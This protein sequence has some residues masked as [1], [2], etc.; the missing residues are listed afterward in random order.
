MTGASTADIYILPRLG[1]QCYKKAI[2]IDIEYSWAY[3][4]LSIAYKR[5]GDIS[6]YVRNLK[7]SVRL[8]KREGIKK[9]VSFFKMRRY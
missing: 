7:R 5:E 2:E 9:V 4:N 1:K 8:E 6:N 3:H